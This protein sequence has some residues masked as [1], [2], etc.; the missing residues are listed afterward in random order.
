MSPVSKYYRVEHL[1]NRQLHIKNCMCEKLLGINFDYKLNFAKHIEDICPTASRKL[2]AL[3][4]A[5]KRYHT[6]TIQ[7]IS[8]LAK[9][10]RESYWSKLRLF[11]NKL[12]PK[13]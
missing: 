13:F 3:A 8:F 1:K 6:V 5:I 9:R 2:N 11:L 7:L 4:C 12:F 10:F